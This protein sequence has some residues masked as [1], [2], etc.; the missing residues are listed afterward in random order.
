MRNCLKV[1]CH[2]KSTFRAFWGVP[3]GFGVVI[4]A[5]GFFFV[6][7]FQMEN[8]ATKMFEISAEGI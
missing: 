8:F 5:C 1:N 3:W 4:D 7:I 2:E 6:E